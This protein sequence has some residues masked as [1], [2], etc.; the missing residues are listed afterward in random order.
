MSPVPPAAEEQLVTD[1][2]S[3]YWT[4]LRVQRLRP[5]LWRCFVLKDQLENTGAKNQCRCSYFNAVANVANNG[6]FFDLA[7]EYV[8]I[9]AAIQ[10]TLKSGTNMHAG[11]LAGKARQCWMQIQVLIA[12]NI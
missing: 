12:R 9:E 2:W 11:L 1:V 10:Q 5:S 3:S 8:D 6:E 7:T 4:N